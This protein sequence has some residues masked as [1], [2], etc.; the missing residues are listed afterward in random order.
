MADTAEFGL[1]LRDET[2]GAAAAAGASLQGMQEAMRGAA[3]E[4][5]KLNS[6]LK[7]TGGSAS[8]MSAEAKAVADSMGKTAKEANRLAREFEGAD[9]ASLVM[10]DHYGDMASNFG[11]FGGPIGNTVMRFYELKEAYTKLSLFAG[12]GTA[13]FAAASL[14]FAALAAVAL[15]ATTAVIAL[16][17][18]L[19]KSAISA[20]DAA[21]KIDILREGMTGSAASAAALSG[22][23]SKVASK[24]PLS[25][26]EV[27]KLADGLWKSGKRGAELEKALLAA[28][29]K[30]AGLGKNPGPDLIARRM[31]NLDVIGMKLSDHIAGIFAGP[32]T[33]TATGKFGTA[34]AG[35]VDLFSKNRS[36]G[37]ALEALLSTIVVPLINGLTAAIPLAHQLFR[38]MI[39]LALMAAIGVLK[40]T[41][42]ILEM[43]PESAK[44]KAAELAGKIDAIAIAVTAGKWVMGL[45]IASLVI[46]AAVFGVVIGVIAAVIAVVFG[47]VTAIASA[48][49]AIG[50]AVSDAV[51]A[52]F[53][54]GAAGLSA[55]G[56][57]ISGLVNGITS[58]SGAVYDAIKS[59]ASGLLSTLTS[60]LEIGSPSKATT[61]VGGYAGQGM[62][63]GIEQE[64][65]AVEDAAT[66][67]VEPL[68]FTDISTVEPPQIAAM[69]EAG[70]Q[71]S[72]G[73]ARSGPV[74]I[75]IPLKIEGM[76]AAEEKQTRGVIAQLCEAIETGLEQ[77]GIPATVAIA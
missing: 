59:M 4:L 65:Q 66:S 19:V 25:T 51:G 18:A 68:A 13:I 56:D 55:A 47:L 62:A 41:N 57:L 7:S 26:A 53:E 30:A 27:G 21:S 38:G 46:V 64:A 15:I 42:A 35:F 28:S 2:S 36:E 12:K 9:K 77:A 73:G 48:A 74:S 31:A 60:T 11:A 20:S 24:V 49:V 44:A 50:G 34:L 43:I 1:V 45:F 3:S 8:E 72:G 39:I 16:G 76:S 32:K 6:D 14:G 37:R 75:T 29:Y 40:A 54:L 17:V 22:S 33:K 52:L 5:Q 10:A 58:G 69:A 23:I 67:L 70:R 61:R 63:I 71:A